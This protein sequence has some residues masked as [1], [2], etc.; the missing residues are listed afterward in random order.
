MA[1]AAFYDRARSAG[2][3]AVSLDPS[4]EEGWVAE[5]R[6][7]KSSL[8]VVAVETPCPRTRAARAPRLATVDREERKS[9][10]E[11]ARLTVR[12]ASDVGAPAVIVKLGALD[13]GTAWQKVVKEFARQSLSRPQVERLIGDRVKATARALDLARYGLEPI[14]DAAASAGVV[15]ALTNR[16]RWFE[17]PDDAELG[18]L[19]ED[20]RGGPLATWYDAAAGHVRDTLGFGRFTEWLAVH[21]KRAAG[22]YFGDACGLRGGL[23]WGRGEV[24]GATVD[25]AIPETVPRVVH[26]TPDVTDE[27][28]ATSLA[29]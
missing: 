24:D 7:L 20:F 25:A 11:A 13:I 28:L 15:L 4:L 9:A 18:V 8:P 19:L 23:P 26:V 5:W 12:L 2:A 3:S 22:V 6:A 10:V 1:P 21:G 29:G 27:E 14:L 16:A 17:I